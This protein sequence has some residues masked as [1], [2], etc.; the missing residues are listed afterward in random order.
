MKNKKILKLLSAF[1]AAAILS[2]SFAL[3]ATA[4]DNQLFDVTAESLV[5]QIGDG[6]VIDGAN[7]VKFIKDTN[8]DYDIFVAD[9]TDM[10]FD[11]NGHRVTFGEGDI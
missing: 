3:S 1:A 5:E 4:A 2:L 9:G 10:I 11:L 7:T 8:I 6:A